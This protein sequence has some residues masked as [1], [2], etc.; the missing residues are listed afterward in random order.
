MFSYL[1]IY[2][3]IIIVSVSFNIYKT[4]VFNLGAIRASRVIHNKLLASVVGSTFR[5][6]FIPAVELR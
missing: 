2:G 3:L 1:G 4:I 6:V 5:W